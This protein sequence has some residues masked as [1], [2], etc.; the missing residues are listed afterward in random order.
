MLLDRFG[1]SN[2]FWNKSYKKWWN[3]QVWVLWTSSRGRPE[4]ALETSQ[5]NCPGT[6]V[7]RQIRT[8]PGCHF[9][10]S[11]GRHIGTSP[12]QSNRIFRGHLGTLEGDVLG[13]S[14]EPIFA[15][16]VVFYL[17][18]IPNF[19]RHFVIVFQQIFIFFH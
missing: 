16:W 3:I 19:I 10:T 8:S 2:K 12:S 4:N 15:G 7:E 13:T 11:P 6:S 18:E 9:R 17:N 1:P 5:I 14:W